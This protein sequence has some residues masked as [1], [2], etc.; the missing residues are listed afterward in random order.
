MRITWSRQLGLIL[1]ACCFSATFTASR[2]ANRKCNTVLALKRV[3]G[4][5]LILFFRCR[6]GMTKNTVKNEYRM[7]CHQLK[8]FFPPYQMSVKW[9]CT[10]GLATNYNITNAFNCSMYSL[11]K[12]SSATLNTFHPCQERYAMSYWYVIAL[13][14]PATVSL[15]RSLSISAH[16]IQQGTVPCK[17]LSHPTYPHQWSRKVSLVV[18]APC[19]IWDSIQA[20]FFLGNSS[21]NYQVL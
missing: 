2:T 21:P 20:S 8:L 15:N 1:P 19:Y 13:N 10:A 7:K 5:T 17:L 12:Y 16:T 9:S 18:K 11:H 6:H 14:F 4:A 3:A